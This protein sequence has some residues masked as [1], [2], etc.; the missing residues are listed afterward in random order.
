M[1]AGTLHAREASPTF[2]TSDEVFCSSACQCC[3]FLKKYLLV[4]LNE[5]K[6]LSEIIKILNEELE[7]DSVTKREWMSDSTCKNHG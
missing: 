3:S 6:S 5:I 7:Y 4:Y 1:V 2:V